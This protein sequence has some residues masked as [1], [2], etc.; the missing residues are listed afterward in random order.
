MNMQRSINID[1]GTDILSLSIFKHIEEVMIVLAFMTVR[2]V[3]CI[4]FVTN[5]CYL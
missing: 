1:T 2:Q 4:E 3:E 5:E